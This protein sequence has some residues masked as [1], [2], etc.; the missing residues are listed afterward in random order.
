MMVLIAGASG[1]IGAR[2]AAACVA[3]GD[4][5]VCASRN[6]REPGLPGTRHARLDYTAMPA[7][8]RLAEMLDGVD[9]VVNAVGILRER[10]AQTFEA[11]HVTG[12]AALFSAAARAGVRR[13]VQVSALGAEDGASARYHSSKH[14][15]DLAL[16]TLPVDWVI[17]QP[18]LVY[19]AG[20]TSARLFEFLASLPVTM[21]RG[22][23]TWS[24]PSTVAR[25]CVVI[26][27]SVG[28]YDSASSTAC[29]SSRPASG[30]GWRSCPRTSLEAWAMK[31]RHKSR[32]RWRDRSM[33][34]RSDRIASATVQRC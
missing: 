18:S 5:V 7:A 12:P 32:R 29:V 6:G 24:T 3:A 16:A 17:V 20:G 9:V 13:I 30:R 31:T 25:R 14:R 1:F 8:E 10:G 23:P 27:P 21:P 28:R 19:G 22:A 26:G 34:A 2:L 11:L 4:T 15:A 33:P